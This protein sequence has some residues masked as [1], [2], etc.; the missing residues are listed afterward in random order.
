[1]IRDHR[2]II[3]STIRS[4]RCWPVGQDWVLPGHVLIGRGVLKPA[5][6]ITRDQDHGLRP[7]S[8]GGTPE[9]CRNSEG[10][11][12]DVDQDASQGGRDGNV[13]QDKYGLQDDADLNLAFP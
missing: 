9:R 8:P 1:M 5:R 12:R 11:A 2:P 13:A 3:P 7:R 4:L 10:P 6:S